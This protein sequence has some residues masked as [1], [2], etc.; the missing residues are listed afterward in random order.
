MP[1]PMFTINY[2][3]L[4]KHPVGKAASAFLLLLCGLLALMLINHAR[5]Y[6]GNPPVEFYLPPVILLVLMSY[7]ERIKVSNGKCVLD[8][9][10]MGVKYKSMEFLSAD[11]ELDKKYA[12]FLFQNGAGAYGSNIV[13]PAAEAE[14]L[15]TVILSITH[16]PV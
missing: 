8:K 6:H 13:Y 7:V 4:L 15:L 9:S 14:R 12:T 1:T 10:F 2:R 16:K 5:L 3:P 11:L